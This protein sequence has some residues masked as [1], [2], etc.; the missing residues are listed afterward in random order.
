MKNKAILFILFFIN[1]I[2]SFAFIHL[3]PSDMRVDY[4]FFDLMAWIICYVIYYIYLTKKKLFDIN[5]FSL[6]FLYYCISLL[7][8]LIFNTILAFGF[9][10]IKFLIFIILSVV[11]I[12]ISDKQ[13]A[14]LA[15]YGPHCLFLSLA[16]F[17]TLLSPNSPIGN[18]ESYTDS[19]V[20]RYI[21]ALMA[22]GEVPYLDSFD[23]KGLLI[24]FINYLP[25]VLNLKYGLWLIETIVIFIAFTFAYKT[26]NLFNKKTV[27]I[28]SVIV[29]FIPIIY[30][31]QGGNLTEE[32]ALPFMFISLYLFTRDLK[33][34]K[35][36]T[37]V[38]A[39]IIGLC[40]GAVFLLRINMLVLWVCMALYLL[41]M[42]INKKDYKKLFNNI[43]SFIGGLIVFMIPFTIYLI[44]NGAFGE[45]INQY[46]IFNLKYVG[47]NQKL[48]LVDTLVAFLPKVEL[49]IFALFALLVFTMQT[50]NK[51]YYIFL[52]SYLILTIFIV[53]LP[54]SVYSHYAMILIPALLV[55]IAL[56]IDVVYK[57][58]FAFAKTDTS[59]TMFTYFA[60]ICLCITDFI[61]VFD[62]EKNMFLQP[63]QYTGVAKIV[64]RYTEKDDN[65]LVCGNM[66]I[67]YLAS[68]RYTKIKYSY[69]TPI[70]NVDNTLAKD[71]LKQFNQN[72]PK[73]IYVDSEYSVKKIDK[74]MNKILSTDYEIV[75]DGKYARIYLAKTIK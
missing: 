48:P 61:F 2:L 43:V 32:Y 51:S 46:L 17:I 35:S 74:V 9:L 68:D 6:L 15:Q 54:G 56:V 28:I 33:K 14:S 29:A 27:S 5:K 30:T 19:S 53:I 18:G 63:K 3:F 67:V 36:V 44:I 57:K 65:I 41:V 21:G 42:Y 11:D 62:A 69:Q 22:H 23:H 58:L 38:S 59:R 20:F 47:G 73:L 45:F 10:K 49:C 55:P 72:R 4:L 39:L 37:N 25:L 7:L 1:L 12:F 34:Q 40:A 52:L 31:Y 75:H 8:I 16:I 71:F 50:K 24:Y 66:N 64:Q 13:K 60:I 70:L 26:C